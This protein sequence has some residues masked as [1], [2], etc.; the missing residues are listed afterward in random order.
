MTIN[1]KSDAMGNDSGTDEATRIRAALK[2]QPL[3]LSIKEI[4]AVVGMSRNSVA[5]YLEVLT[6]TGQL[7]LRHVGN[8]KLYTLSRRVPVT[9]IINYARELIIVLDKSLRIVEASDSLCTFT[10]ATRMEILHTHLSS[11]PTC[12]LTIAEEDTLPAL[13]NGGP[14]WK[15]EIRLI[16]GPEE[17]YLDSRF[18]PTMLQ[19]GE[20][21]ITIILE[22]ITGRRRAEREMQERDRLL[23]T[24]FQIPSVPRFFI[25]KN[26]KVVFW[27]RA[28]EI[29]TGF[30]SEEMVG[31]NQHW[32]AFYPEEHA[33]LADLLVDGDFTGLASA[34][35][36]KCRTNPTGDGGYECTEYFYG[37]RP[38]GKWL[39]ITASLIR[40]STGAI[41]GAME[42]VEDVTEKKMR[43]FVIE[44]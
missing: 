4:S 18:I 16:Q 39:H 40:D 42:T 3:G 6:A 20:P 26:H 19:N 25:D 22:D 21:G 36:S 30:K 15:K 35:Q 32:K 23:H 31:T 12:L 5:K 41:T 14:S 8:A 13:L 17:R 33:C 44:E 34:Y 7:E 24:I 29:L 27:D 38:S 37:L 9:N 11:P 10:G 43:E 28:L 1:G 2:D